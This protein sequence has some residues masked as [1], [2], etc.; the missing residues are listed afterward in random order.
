MVIMHK[1]LLFFLLI[2]HK[3]DK[4]K[5]MTSIQTNKSK[6]KNDFCKANYDRLN[7]QVPKGA[8]AMIEDY[9]KEKGFKSLNDY[10][11]SLIFNDMGINAKNIT[12]GDIVQKGD[13]NTVNIG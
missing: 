5:H 7:I 3:I 4:E 6:Y 2:M 9:R 1:I 8:K 12:V 11:N 10:V 13:N